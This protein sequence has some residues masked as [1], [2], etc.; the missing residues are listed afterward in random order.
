[1]VGLTEWKKYSSLLAREG[2]LQKPEVMERELCSRNLRQHGSRERRVK[3]GRREKTE[4][5][6]KFLHIPA[7]SYIFLHRGGV[8]AIN[9]IPS[10]S[11]FSKCGP[12]GPVPGPRP[13]F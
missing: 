10:K 2:W 4:E 3:E 7:Y 6:I 12:L 13:A 9:P 8:A 1:M 11:T 5:I